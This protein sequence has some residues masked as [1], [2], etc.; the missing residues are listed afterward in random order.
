MKK[1]LSGVLMAMATAT[2]GMAQSEKPLMRDFI[3]INVH[4]VQFDPKLYRPVTRL[5]RDYHPY[6][7]DVNDK[8]GSAT[9]FPKAMHI[10]WK[11]PA[12]KFRDWNKPVDWKE[13]YGEW[14]GLGYDVNASIQIEAVA[15]GEWPDREKNLTEYGKAFAAY[16]GPS[17]QNLVASAEIGN[18]PAGNNKYTPE[19]Y[20]EVFQIMAKALRAGDPKLKIVSCAVQAGK[21]DGYCQPI[22][23]L[24]GESD[25]Y[26]VINLHQY[27]LLKG[28]PSFERTF[29]EDERFRF[30]GVLE[31]AIKW[32]DEHAAGKP[33]WITEFG[34][35]AST[36]EPAADNAQWKDC[37]DLQ[38]AQWIVRSFLTL[39]EIDL[40]RAYLYWFNDGDTPSFHAS[41]G[42]TRDF[43]PKPSYWAM[44]HLYEALGDYRLNAAIEKD[45]NGAYVFEYVNGEDPTKLVWVAWS[46]TGSEKQVD[47]QLKLP[48]KVT[49][50]QRMPTAKDEK[51][52][53]SVAANGNVTL[54]ESPLYIWIQK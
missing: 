39:S 3:G 17:N 5:V 41:S 26:D 40:Q 36:K 50:A 46:P 4:T 20:K 30:I 16:F 48:G 53:V 45:K 24:K 11:A 32:R 31:D 18:E 43:E 21:T 19:Q 51:T 28:W 37:T 23:V 7:W 10:G 1:L 12:G 52:D 44:A 47:R 9:N 14:V 54:T 13:L 33:V 8:P 6:M 27:A 15:Y 22:D 2:T 25:L 35:D 38:Q 42:I 49:K 34:Y 29:P